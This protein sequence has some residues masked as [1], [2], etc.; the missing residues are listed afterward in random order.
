M[1]LYS[2]L[3]SSPIALATAGY[4]LITSLGYSFLCGLALILIIPTVQVLLWKEYEKLW[5]EESKLDE[6]KS[7]AIKELIDNAKIIKLYGWVQNWIKKVEDKAD[8]LL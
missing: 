3:L 5:E 7:A 4:I 6:K 2:S 8:D 1:R